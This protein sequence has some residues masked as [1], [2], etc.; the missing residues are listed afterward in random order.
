MPW[1][2]GS[3]PFKLDVIPLPAPKGDP[4]QL[5]LDS[6]GIVDVLLELAAPP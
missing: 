6:L 3:P 4:P 2:G 5:L 1:R